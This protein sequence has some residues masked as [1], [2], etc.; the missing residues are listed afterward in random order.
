MRHDLYNHLVWNPSQPEVI[1]TGP[2][3]KVKDVDI[4]RIHLLQEAVESLSP[5]LDEH[6]CLLC[7]APSVSI[8]LFSPSNSS[9]FGGQLGM[10]KHFVYTLCEDHLAVP[11]FYELVEEFIAADVLTGLCER[12]LTEH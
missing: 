9:S 11:R 8:S 3:W 5:I 1:F 4:P 2:D 10:K 7:D 6:P 12:A